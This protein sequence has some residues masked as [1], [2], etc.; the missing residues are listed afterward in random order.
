MIGPATPPARNFLTRLVDRAAG[1]DHLVEPRIPSV[2]EPA[3]AYHAPSGAMDIA[4]PVEQFVDA[5]PPRTRADPWQADG[6]PRRV[7]R[8]RDTAEQPLHAESSAAARVKIVAPAVHK[9][10]DIEAI[11]GM[12]R[13]AAIVTDARTPDASLDLR[14]AP[15]ASPGRH[16][17]AESTS[18]HIS[19]GRHQ[20]DDATE[21]RD[22][23][24]RVHSQSD[25]ADPQARSPLPVS[26]LT[27]KQIHA[28]LPGASMRAAHEPAPRDVHMPAADPVVRISIGRV[29]VRAVQPAVAATA[30]RSAPRRPMNL[31]EYLEKSRRAR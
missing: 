21:P 24:H 16:V 2:F 25:D 19:V 14:V 29:E 26:V 1:R 17:V 27:P 9:E 28:A 6:A 23:T 8:A 15:L 18:E 7:D 11:D 3:S 13:H 31:D 10:S 5:E 30:P 4:A 22:G 20:R 12:H